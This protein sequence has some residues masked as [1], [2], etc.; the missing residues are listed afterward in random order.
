M[1]ADP[2]VDAET[3]GASTEPDLLNELRQMVI[4]GS[5][6]HERTLQR[7]IGPSEVGHP[8]LRRLALRLTKSPE[9]NTYSDPL[10]SA[11]GTGAHAE[12]D[13]FARRDNQRLGRTRWLPEQRVT[14]RPGLSGTSDLVDLDT[15]TIIDH[16]F[17][18]TSR[19]HEY[20]SHGPSEQYRVQ[21]HLY[22]RGARNMGLPIEHVAIAFWPRGGQMKNAH[23]WTEPYDDELVSRQLSRIDATLLLLDDLNVDEHPERYQQVPATPGD[24]F[25]CP[26]Y[27]RTPESPQQCEGK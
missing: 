20:R 4:Y 5:S 1:T 24:C 16:K 22:G 26:F 27:K 15:M 6:Q 14:V 19:L 7:D 13:T 11:V 3:F 9:I 2:F 17:P 10:P 21:A 25:L 23:L 18:G 12:F 8:C